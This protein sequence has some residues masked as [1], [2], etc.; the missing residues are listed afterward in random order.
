M[1]KIFLLKIDKTE[2]SDKHRHLYKTISEKS[3][4]IIE[5]LPYHTNKKL[6]L[7]SDLLLRYLI[8]DRLKINNYDLVFSKNK[9]GKPFLINDL[10]FKYSIS[11]TSNALV[12]AISNHEIGIDIEENREVNIDL[13]KRFFHRNEYNYISEKDSQLRFFEIWTKKEAYI[14]FIGK[15]FSVKPNSFDVSRNSFQKILTIYTGN[16][17]I[18]LCSKAFPVLNSINYISEKQL[19][20]KIQFLLE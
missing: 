9:Y 2:F 6:R 17:V 3:K 10:N 20:N 7:Y 11:Y 16:Y 12:I 8:C 19:L 14:K 4:E 1:I 15:G 18:S 5:R 13:A